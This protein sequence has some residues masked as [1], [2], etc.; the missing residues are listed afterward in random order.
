MTELTAGPTSGSGA[1]GEINVVGGDLGGTRFRIALADSSGKLLHRSGIRTEASR[2]QAAVLERIKGSIRDTIALARGPVGAIAIAAPGPLD[3]WKGIIYRPPNL[4]G[5]D[6]VH[7]KEILEDAFGIPTHVGNDANLA[8]M[9]EWR[10]GAGRGSSHVVYVTVST[11]VGGGVI[12]RGQLLLGFCGGAAEVGHMTIDV[13]G[14]RCNCGNYGDLEALASGTAISRRAVESIK[15]GHESRIVEL[16]G[17]LEK[18]AAEHVVEAARQ[19]DAVALE[20]LHRAGYYLGVGVANLM[21]L[22]DP[23]VIVLGGGVM[24]AKDLLFA[25]MHRA[26]EERAMLSFRLR[27]RIELAVLGDDVGIYGAVAL[28]LSQL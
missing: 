16:A 4:P 28:A 2:G 17:G 8:A 26:I 13:N 21:M 1:S 22:Y 27:T 15:A 19:G 3:P 11:G 25:E 20:V 6:E 7:L 14:P 18:V 23:E 12:D 5:W 9:A 10:F 24:N